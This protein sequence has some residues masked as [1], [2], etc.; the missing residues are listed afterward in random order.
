VLFVWLHDTSMQRCSCLAIGTK[1]LCSLIV[2][3][4][5]AERWA[6]CML[7]A[8][9]LIL[10]RYIVAYYSSLKHRPAATDTWCKK[11]AE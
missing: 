6:R 10:A 8:V 2:V 9:Q 11:W 4:T 5:I 7:S 1:M 3:C